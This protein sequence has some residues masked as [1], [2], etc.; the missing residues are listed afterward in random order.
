MNDKLD[1]KTI[2]KSK[3]PDSHNRGFRIKKEAAAPKNLECPCRRTVEVRLRYGGNILVFDCGETDLEIGVWVIVKYQDVTRIGMVTSTPTRFTSEDPK[4]FVYLP[5]DREFLR[6]ATIDDLARQAENQ[7]L[8]RDEYEF[9]YSRI[10][11][12]ELPMKLVT[13][14]ITFDNYKSIFYYTAD[15]RVD[16]RQLVKDLVRRLR[17]R[18]EMRQISVRHE[19]LMLGG[20]GMCG[21]Q[22]CCSSFLKNFTPVSVRMAKD[23]HLS[24][25][26]V[27]ISGV[28]GRLMCCLAFENHP[29]D[30]KRPGCELGQKID[31]QNGDIFENVGESTESLVEEC[32]KLAE[33]ELRDPAVMAEFNET[34]GEPFQEPSRP[35]D[36]G[37]ISN[38]LFGKYEETGKIIYAGPD[39]ETP[40]EI[41]S[42]NKAET[43]N[44]CSSKDELP[45]DQ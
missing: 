17:T 13:V 22:L 43:I 27:K 19:A 20:M 14:E 11:K 15:E 33:A 5:K 12:L 36:G 30:G 23:Q 6:V 21:R 38:I 34:M 4:D 29:S 18:V 16:F 42:E 10:K 25:N 8:E 2:P 44:D 35:F 39:D 9:C 24:I 41:S 32:D 37:S 31:A 26:T 28:C 40:R 45:K 3:Y 1:K 7:L